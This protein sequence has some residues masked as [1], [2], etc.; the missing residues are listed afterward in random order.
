MSINIS[1]TI[2]KNIV[3]LQLNCESVSE[4]NI[5]EILG[6]FSGGKNVVRIPINNSEW[7]I[8][9][10][11][12]IKNKLFIKHSNFKLAIVRKTPLGDIFTK[13]VD[14]DTPNTIGFVAYLSLT[15][16]WASTASE[17]ESKANSYQLGKLYQYPI[18]CIN[19]Y[20]EIENGK[21][22]V[23]SILDKTKKNIHLFY[24]NKLAYLFDQSSIIYDYFPCSLDCSKTIKIGKYYEEL[25]IKVELNEMYS[26]IKNNLKKPI[27]IGDGFL[28]QTN[29]FPINNIFKTKKNINLNIPKA[30]LNI[31]K[32]DGNI[33]LYK[34]KFFATL[35]TFIE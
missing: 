33:Y 31:K 13:N 22:W 19:A 14:W 34:N 18:C 1:K 17:L 2:I 12:G 30:L 8:I 3:D 32:T 7:S 27:L 15:K 26:K 4:R 10:E 5:L 9:K 25:L 6:L 20:K 11:F 28:V 23:E 16:K 24:A 29:G 21:F 35:H